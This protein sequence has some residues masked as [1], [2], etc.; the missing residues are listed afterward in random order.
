M[1]GSSTVRTHVTFVRHGETEWNRT[2]RVQGTSDI[3]LNDTGRLQALTTAQALSSHH[4]T[5]VFASPLSRAYE[6]AQI[7]SSHLGLDDPERL[8]GVVERNY[9][10]AEGLTDREIESRWPDGF[11]VPGRESRSAVVARALPA[12][13]ELSERYPGGHLLVV[14]HGGVIGSL[15][16][17]LTNYRVPAPG[18]AIPNGSV[19]HFVYENGTLS[20]EKF[21]LIPAGN[22][23]VDATGR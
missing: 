10:D 16:R 15:T 20:L 1:T 18:Q 22:T 9:G 14:S 2:K 6:T 8:A 23:L 17:H 4:F 19:H 5:A 12:L 13:C 21:N 3:P 11:S 7:I